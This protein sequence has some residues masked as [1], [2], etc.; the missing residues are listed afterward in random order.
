M[1]RYVL[2]SPPD[3]HNEEETGS[4]RQL[5]MLMTVNQLP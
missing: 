3:S 4:E 1:T 2:P 5:F